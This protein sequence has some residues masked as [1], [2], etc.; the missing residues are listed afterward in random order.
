[1]RYNTAS[2]EVRV[3][4]RTLEVEID[5]ET[6]DVAPAESLPLTYRYFVA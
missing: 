4:P 6:V 1:M 5:G 3:D 2:P